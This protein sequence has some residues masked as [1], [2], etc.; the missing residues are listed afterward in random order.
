MMEK[1]FTAMWW[2]AKHLFYFLLYAEWE[3]NSW[4]IITITNLF[5]N[6]TIIFGGNQ[7]QTSYPEGRAI[8]GKVLLYRFVSLDGTGAQ[9]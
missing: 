2:Q 4:F 7:F 3:I 5:I 1:G 6:I 8:I 9:W